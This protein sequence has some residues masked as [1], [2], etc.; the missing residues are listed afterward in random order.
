MTT[1]T[2]TGVA[3]RWLYS[4]L[5]GDT[6]PGGVATLSP[7]GVHDT[8]APAGATYPLTIFR[9]QGGSDLNAQGPGRRVYV[10]AIY[11]VYAITRTASYAPIEPIA[12][13]I[14]ALLNGQSG[15]ATG[16]IVLACTR[17]SPL[18]LPSLEDGV[19]ARALG[20]I[21][22]IYSQLT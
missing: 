14:D 21:Y 3:A 10:N 22:R 9:F 1:A 19:E 8:R 13:R 11:A 7:G 18:V 15:T 4:L 20:G 17:Q 2:E 6:G 16:G 5:S 12:A